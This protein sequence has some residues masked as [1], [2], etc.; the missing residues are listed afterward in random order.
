MLIVLCLPEKLA[1]RPPPLPRDAEEA[2]KEVKE[3]HKPPDTRPSTLSV[4][5]QAAKRSS[6]A[7]TERIIEL[8]MILFD[9]FRCFIYLRFP[10]LATTILLASFTFGNL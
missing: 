1:A 8:R 2:A 7:L 9:P 3:A 4:V 5:D 6:L 10:A